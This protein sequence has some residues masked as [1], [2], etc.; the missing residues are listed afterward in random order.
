MRVFRRVDQSSMVP[1]HGL[2]TPV[3]HTLDGTPGAVGFLGEVYSL[4]FGMI[5]PFRTRQNW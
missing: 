3:P 5:R 2:A 4:S 1:T